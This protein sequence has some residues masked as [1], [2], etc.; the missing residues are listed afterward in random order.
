[1]TTIT[2][3]AIDCVLKGEGEAKVQYRGSLK[4]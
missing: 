3:G 1:M 2:D 4:L